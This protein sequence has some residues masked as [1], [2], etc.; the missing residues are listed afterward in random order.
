MAGDTSNTAAKHGGPVQFPTGSPKKPIAIE[1]LAK[2][3]PRFDE[4]SGP[5]DH[6]SA[7]SKDFWSRV[8]QAF[9]LE[10]HH[11]RLLRLAC[12]A[13]DRG[14]NARAAIAAQG[15][16]FEDRFGQLKAHP[17]IGVERDCRLAVA[18]LLRELGLDV[19]GGPAGDADAR[20]PRLAGKR[21]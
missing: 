15:E 4:E 17:A 18:R 19:E 12:E 2:G 20:P 9:D 21:L 13:F 8:I 10:D 6:L 7:E 1:A 5:P 16:Y 14:Q 11:L 3:S